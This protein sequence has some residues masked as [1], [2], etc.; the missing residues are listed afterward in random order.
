VFCGDPIAAAYVII[1][2]VAGGLGAAVG[3]GVDALVRRSPNLY[4]RG[5]GARLT[6]APALGAGIR[7]AV[8]SVRW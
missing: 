3:V 8:V 4:R 6:L 2:A 7:G 5:N 1:P